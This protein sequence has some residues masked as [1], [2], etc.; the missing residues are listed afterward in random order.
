MPVSG[1]LT[2]GRAGRRLATGRVRAASGSPAGP[3]AG[4]RRGERRPSTTAR[5]RPA[6]E[7]RA[8]VPPAS[9][10]SSVRAR[11]DRSS[12][13]RR[14]GRPARAAIGGVDRRPRPIRRAAPAP[15]PA[16]LGRGFRVGRR[17]VGAIA[18]PG[19]RP[20]GRRHRHSPPPEDERRVL[21]AEA[22]RVRQR[23][24]DVLAPGLPGR[25]V[26]ALGGVV[27]IVEVDRRRDAALAD[28]QDRGRSP[29]SRR[30]RRACARSSTCWPSP[31]PPGARRRRSSGSPGAP[32]GRPPASTSRGR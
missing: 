31:R 20:I 4:H 29:R 27:R 32:P 10:S 9:T 5:R 13:P 22:E 11:S 17:D 23:D 8:V 28:R 16:E 6:C 12:R 25:Q 14:A 7:G 2:L 30:P 21:A 3:A 26:E 15:R 1:A 18:R 19:A 24:L